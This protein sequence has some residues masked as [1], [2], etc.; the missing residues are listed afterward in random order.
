[1][2]NSSAVTGSAIYGLAWEFKTAQELQPLLDSFD[3]HWGL[4]TFEVARLVVG[5]SNAEVL[6][7]GGHITG[8][9]SNMP[10]PYKAVKRRRKV[11]DDPSE[12][13]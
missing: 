8:A 11:V 3:T 13:V 4:N 1:M 6:Q 5:D 7:N 12:L 9:S 10:N 2:K